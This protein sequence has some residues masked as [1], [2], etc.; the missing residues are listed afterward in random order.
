MGIDIFGMIETNLSWTHAAWT[1][2]AAMIR[3]KFDYGSS[4][5][6]SARQNKEGYLS[7]GT[8][9]I[10]RGQVTGRGMKRFADSMGRYTYMT[11]RGKDGSGVIIITIYRVYQT[12]VLILDLIL[13]T[14][15]NM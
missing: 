6:S 4:T 15:S 2:L 12:L 11:L 5:T 7:G 1:T 10:I 8:A 13:H 14:H 9:M 3:M